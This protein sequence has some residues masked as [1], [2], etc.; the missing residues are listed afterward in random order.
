MSKKAKH[1]KLEEELMKL[2]ASVCTSVDEDMDG[3][4]RSDELR[5]DL[6]DS[7]ELLKAEGYLT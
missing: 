4:S 7:F 1:S 2:L 6:E 3:D 5:S